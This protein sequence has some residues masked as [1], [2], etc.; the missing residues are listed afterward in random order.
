MLRGIDHAHFGLASALHLKRSGILPLTGETCAREDIGAV[1]TQRGLGI[2]GDHGRNED[3][4]PA[5]H[6]PGER[7]D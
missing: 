5:R 7:E 3:A 6:G 2:L 1:I 4:L